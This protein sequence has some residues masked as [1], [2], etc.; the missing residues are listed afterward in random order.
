MVIRK[1]SRREREVGPMPVAGA[2]TQLVLRDWLT[3]MLGRRSPGI[4]WNLALTR[5]RD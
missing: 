5:N 2:D 4:S 3:R 1:D